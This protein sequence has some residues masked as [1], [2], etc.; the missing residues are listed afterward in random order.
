MK[1]EIK[2]APQNLNEVIYPNDATALRMKGYA[3]GKLEGN[4]LLHGT[5]GTGKTS[6]A[7]LLPY[8][9]AG[10]DAMIE[11]KEHDQVLSQSNIKQ[12]LQ[13]ACQNSKLFGA[14][15]FFLVFNEFDNAKVNLSK[16]WTAMDACAD[17]LMVI[18]TTNQPMSVHQS[19]RSRCDIVAMPPL[20]AQAVLARAQFILAAEGLVLPDQQVL[21][22]LKTKQHFGDLRKYMHAIDELLLLQSMGEPMPA[23]TPS[24]PTLSVVKA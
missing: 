1:T 12:Y 21:H 14:G 18:I 8:A 15:K 16:L 5:N 22:Y 10:A 17:S 19:I 24:A 11:D 9:I 4:I 13:N 2:Y 3:A 6:I 23:W 7:K 20:T